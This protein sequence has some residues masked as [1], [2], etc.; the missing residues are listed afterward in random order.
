VTTAERALQQRD[1]ADP[2]YPSWR[3]TGRAE[4]MVA[5]VL[6]EAH[7]RGKPRRTVEDVMQ[8]TRHLGPRRQP[9]VWAVR[10]ALERMEALGITTAA[11]RG[12]TSAWRLSK[13]GLAAMGE[14]GR[15][16]HPGAH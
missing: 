15:D 2:L 3:P 16:A 1:P 10:Q 4:A 11:H 6:L 5:V 9:P 7:R 13:R 14:G 8:A 12:N